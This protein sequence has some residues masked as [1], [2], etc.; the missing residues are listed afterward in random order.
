MKKTIKIQP[1]DFHAT[2]SPSGAGRW[3]VCHGSVAANAAIPSTDTQGSVYAEEGTAAHKLLELCLRMDMEP[4]ELHGVN[5]HKDFHVNDDMVDAV[6]HAYDYIKAHLAQHPG[7]YVGI[8]ERVHWG[9]YLG[10]AEQDSS[11]TA[12]AV[13]LWMEG[14]RQCVTVID[15]K[16]GAGKVVEVAHNPQLKLYGL[17]ALYKFTQDKCKQVG[18]VIIQP[19][20]RHDEGPVR[21]WSERVD[22]LE[23]W[24]KTVVAPAAKAALRPNAKR[25]AGSHCKWCAA[26][27]TC[28]ALVDH[29]MEQAGT[30][31]GD[32]EVINPVDPA[33]LNDDQLAVAMDATDAIEIWVHAVRGR[34]LNMLMGGRALAGWKLVTGRRTREWVDNATSIVETAAGH[35]APGQFAPRVLLSPA[36]ME[37]LYKSKKLGPMFNNEMSA[38]IT[39]SKAKPVVA[40]E[41]DPRDP[42]QPGSEFDALE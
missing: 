25:V 35:F 34:V 21:E 27:P 3:L 24:L 7:T 41:H 13:L 14:K 19:R 11:G 33:T 15:Y 42:Y 4:Y 28:R 10:I 38:Y 2:L 39:R 23:H 9:G 36:Q 30:E 31:F 37:A 22:A 6:A 5:I 20:A 26:A 17:G 29:V 1:V 40:P 16:H 12:D 32:I 18:F 8:E